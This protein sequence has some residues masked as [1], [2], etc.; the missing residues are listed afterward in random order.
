M[1]PCCLH[2]VDGP[3]AILAR[4]SNR[5]HRKV[6]ACSVRLNLRRVGINDQ[7]GVVFA[8]ICIAS[9]LLFAIR[10]TSLGQE[11]KGD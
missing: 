7:L 9:P 11:H 10:C 2:I 5:A 4:E 6:L 1:R 3:G 8:L